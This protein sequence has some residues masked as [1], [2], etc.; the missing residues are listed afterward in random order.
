MGGGH[1]KI[2]TKYFPQKPG[3]DRKLQVK[4]IIY[5][6]VRRNNYMVNYIK[7]APTNFINCYQ[8]Q[9]KFRL[10]SHNAHAVSGQFLKNLLPFIS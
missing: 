8:N 4:Q 3:G 10:M 5:S 9:T 2:A 7:Y 1:L 6:W